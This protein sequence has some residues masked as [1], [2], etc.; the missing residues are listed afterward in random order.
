MKISLFCLII[1]SGQLPQQ[2]HLSLSAVDRK[3]QSVTVRNDDTEPA[4]L[5]GCTLI[6]QRGDEVYRFPDDTRLAPGEEITVVCRD[7]EAPGQLIW[8]QDSV[9]K[10][11]GDTALLFDENMNLLDEDPA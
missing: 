4:V 9:W 8:P 5:T 1:P 3:H 11:N 2:L 6:S 10:K 7:S